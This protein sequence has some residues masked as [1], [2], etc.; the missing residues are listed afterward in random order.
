MGLYE[1]PAG[2]CLRGVAYGSAGYEDARFVYLRWKA[3][4]AIPQLDAY[5][6]NRVFA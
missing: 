2:C 5:F 3:G 6:W 4:F 1:V